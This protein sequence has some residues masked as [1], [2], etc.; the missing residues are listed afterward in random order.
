ME[1]VTSTLS[2]FIDKT[3]FEDIP[4][5]IVEDA[6]RILLDSIGCALG[7][8]YTEKGRIAHA[9]STNSASQPESSI[10]GGREKVSAHLASFVNGELL[11][12]LD[13]D[14][15]CAPSGHITPYVLS[16]PL[17]VAE[18]KHISGKGLIVAIALAHE[19]A[20]RLSAGLII[21][22]RLSR[23]TLEQG[24]PLQLP[25][26]GY[27]VNIFGG[28]AAVAKIL[29]LNRSKTGHAFGI[30]GGMCPVPSLMRFAETVPSSMP[31]FAPSGW[32]S[33]AEVTAALLA[34]LG[35]TGD[36]HVFDGEFAFWKSFAAEGWNPGIVVT[37]I[38]NTWFLSNAIGFKRYPCCGAMHGALDIFC[39][40]IDRFDIRPEQIKELNIGLNLLAE[41][42]LWKNRAIK[43]H[44]DAQ[45][46]TAFVFAVAA[47]RIEIGPK[48]QSE[49]T[50]NTP[51]ILA[52][53][54]KVNVFTPASPQAKK[55]NHIVEVHVRDTNKK[56][57]ILYTESDIRPV[58]NN[59]DD[60][61]LG[62]KFANNASEVLPSQKIEK[63]LKMIFALEELDDVSRLMECVSRR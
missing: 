15:L 55:K 60:R 56:N 7:G 31:K 43:N 59:M 11:N 33:Q 37:G 47:H 54:E 62:K 28:I 3:R 45:F 29:G 13:Y 27:G 25:I 23:K 1:K 53:M 44:I 6:K 46:S 5:G 9:F 30:G 32:I 52:F 57:D 20:Q 42:S 51:E 8:L 38:G 39:A 34:E 61:Q 14:A 2:E 4:A 26:H 35:Y 22:E 12:A 16:A 19:I 50:I 10:I 40:I 24:I 21:P 58:Q 63:A 18:W 41:L 36:S 48:W 17:A 49:E